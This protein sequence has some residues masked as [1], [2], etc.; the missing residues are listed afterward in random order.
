M[1]VKILIVGVGGQGTVLASK[2]IGEAAQL[3]GLD[4]KQSEVHGMAQRG[5]SVVTHVKFGDDVY[6]PLVEPGQADYVLAFEQL[7]GLRWISHLAASGK[8]I[9]ST[10]QIMPMPVITGAAKYPEDIES[11][12][13]EAGVDYLMLDAIDTAG[14]LGEKRAANVVLL[15]ALA[16]HLEIGREIWQQAIR[17]VV[18]KRAV[19][20]NLQAFDCG[21]NC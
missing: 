12:F 1:D 14:R 8:L 17:N 10:Q 7:E 15:G 20:V 21:W 18:K 19:D 9:C 2:I 4:V 13:R 16:R 3:A 5:G 11:K 6:S